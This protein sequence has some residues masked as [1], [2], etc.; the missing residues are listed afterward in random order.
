MCM[1]VANKIYLQGPPEALPDSI[2]ESVCGC[3]VSAECVCPESSRAKST[4]ENQQIVTRRPKRR[5]A[6]TLTN[7]PIGYLTAVAGNK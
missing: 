3:N 6:D 1:C 2:A 4:A 7:L 5:H